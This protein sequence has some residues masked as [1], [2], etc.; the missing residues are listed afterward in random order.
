MGICY[1][2]NLTINNHAKTRNKKQNKKKKRKNITAL[3][4]QSARFSLNKGQLMAEAP[5]CFY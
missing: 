4:S 3:N 5:L 2:D 1:A